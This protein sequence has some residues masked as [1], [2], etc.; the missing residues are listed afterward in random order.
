M[1]PRG[2]GILRGESSAGTAPPCDAQGLR[3]LICGGQTVRRFSKLFQ[4]TNVHY[5]MCMTCNH[6]TAGEMHA[7]PAYDGGAY[8]QEIDTGWEGRNKAIRDFV[9]LIA[10]LPAICLSGRS[11]VL[12][13]GCGNGSLVE[14]LNSLG[15]SAYGFEPHAEGAS[16]SDRVFTD[17]NRA[18]SALGQADLIMCI[19]VFEHLHN[20]EEALE[21]ISKT[22]VPGGYL[23]ISTE[24]YETGVHTDDWSYLNPAAGHVS[25]FSESSLRFLL[26]R[27]G[28]E[29]VLRVTGSVWLF[30]DILTRRRSAVERGYFGLSQLRVNWRMRQH[31]RDD[32]QARS[33]RQ[34]E[35]GAVL[36]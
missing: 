8:F 31:H 33:L 1:I 5:F 10:R 18:R 13:F 32:A 2:D 15:F 21:E 4:G 19:E 36:K 35:N 9:R 20:P 23:L 25:I 34:P 27:H 28:F 7:T 12:D 26:S 22:L 11:A 29:P 3:C 24:T 14:D 30:R 17:W 6:L 16:L